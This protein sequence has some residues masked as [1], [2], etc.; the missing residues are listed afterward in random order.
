MAGTSTQNVAV[1]KPNLKVSGGVMFAPLGTTRPT[2]LEAAIDA[3]YASLGYVS[4]D[5]VTETSERSTEDIRAWGGDKVRTVQTEFGT[6]LQFT[7]I[8]SLRAETLKFVY[9]A[10]N[11]STEGGVIT[12][13]RNSQTLPHGQL[14]IPM[15][16]GTNSRH[17][18][19]G[20]A[21]VT[22]V[23][24][25]SYVDGEAIAYEVTVS[26]DPDDDGNTLIERIAVAPADG[27]GETGGGDEGGAT[28]E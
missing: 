1:G 2:S 19:A 14:L 28:G 11:V 25:I 24:D 10:D 7:L 18:D 15:L 3:A 22:E 12:V 21:Q 17:L 6:T 16:D 27:G 4:D 9:G 8:E 13:K 20:L 23:G 5:G 26:C